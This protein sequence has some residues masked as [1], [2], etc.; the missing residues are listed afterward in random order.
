MSKTKKTAKR[1]PLKL[2]KGGKGI[3]VN[4]GK[5]AGDP[6]ISM[7]DAVRRTG[8]TASTLYNYLRD[9]KLPAF[10]VGQSTVFKA[11]DLDK[12]MEPVPYKP[13]GKQTGRTLKAKPVSRPKASKKSSTRKTGS[14]KAR[15]GV[16]GKR[17]P[18]K[19]LAAKEIASL[20][21]MTG[22]AS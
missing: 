1:K 5:L 14:T 21:D 17:R 8:Y 10:K 20:A 16:A 2:V 18:G 4:P 15:S 9:G 19:G 22:S 7:K 3:V 12:L 13:V 6:M 11:S